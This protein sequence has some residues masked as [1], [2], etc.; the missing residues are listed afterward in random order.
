MFSRFAHSRTIVRM[1]ILLPAIS[2]CLLM[3]LAPGRAR[4]S[5]YVGV[6]ALVIA[7]GAVVWRT[8][9]HA[10]PVASLR[11]E[12][13]AV[14]HQTDDGAASAWQQWMVASDRSAARGRVQ[15]GFALSVAI[16]AIIVYAWF[17]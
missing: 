17:A 11:Q 8:W 16:S 14:N 4:S 2:L 12:L 5:T 13:Y 7:T 1:S 10:Q 9:R 3:A 6:M 15:A